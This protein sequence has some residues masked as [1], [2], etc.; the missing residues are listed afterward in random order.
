MRAPADR[1]A[2]SRV[3][4]QLSPCAPQILSW[5][6][7]GSATGDRQ[8]VVDERAVRLTV[9]RRA[10]AG[11]RL[12][13]DALAHGDSREFL[14]SVASTGIITGWMSQSSGLTVAVTGA[15]G[16]LG[17]PFV[18]MLE[19]TAEVARVRAMAR[20][21]FDPRQLGWKKTEYR[22]GDILDRAA[23][24]RFVDGADVVAHLAFIVVKASARSYEIN[25]EGSR[26]VFEATTAAGI[27]R[28]VYTS[29]GMVV[30]GEYISELGRNAAQEV[31]DVMSDQ[32]ASLTL[33]DAGAAVIL[34]RAPDGDGASK[35]P[36]SPRCPST[37]I[38][39]WRSPRRSV[40][41]RRCT[42]T[43]ARSTGP[44]WRRPSRCYARCSIKPGWRST[45][46]II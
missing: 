7:R 14:P 1:V 16:E 32:L 46:S 39:A 13:A 30:S 17:K 11:D 8:P 36:G 35:W 37:A 12:N 42:R 29:R 19:Q 34:E 10:R 15:T 25:I 27:P 3:C 28:L 31:R 33:G 21:P 38:C 41:G 24:E 5:T 9:T 2:V 26:N 40:P 23:V 18:R 4:G 43:L 22:Q 20:R 44:G 45:R 6:W